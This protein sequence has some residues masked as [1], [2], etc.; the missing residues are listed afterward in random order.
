MQLTPR[1]IALLAECHSITA[2]QYLKRIKRLKREDQEAD[3]KRYRERRTD[4][5]QKTQGR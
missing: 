5:S 1:D 3:W 4:G 2:I